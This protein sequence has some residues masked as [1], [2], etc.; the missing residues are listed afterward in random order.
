[1]P[2]SLSAWKE[3]E[4]KWARFFGR[5]ARRH[6]SQGVRYEDISGNWFVAEHK[7]RQFDDYSAEFR[8]AVEQADDN[9]SR[10]PTK[11]SLILF[12]FHN[13]RGT[14]NRYFLM[15]EVPEVRSSSG[16]GSDF[17]AVW[18]RINEKAIQEGEN[19]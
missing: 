8:K 6:S 13:G 9:K 17:M 10:N 1:M 14:P 15:L 2:R 5:G 19:V 7:F 4:R 11:E 18:N 16:G 3:A 12:T